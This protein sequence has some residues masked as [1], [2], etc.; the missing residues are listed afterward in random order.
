MKQILKKLFYY[1][2]V[3]YFFVI[4]L[5]FCLDFSIALFMRW[6][7]DMP[8][9]TST[10]IGF[11]AAL[12]LNYFL[13]ETWVYQNSRKSLSIKRFLL[14][15]LAALLTLLVRWVVLLTLA[16]LLSYGLLWDALMLLVAAFT[17]M[18]L[19]Y[20]IISRI[21]TS[22]PANDMSDGIQ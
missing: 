14:T 2:K 20:I 13:F 16:F 18:V 10:S 6:M 8:L 17:S 7:F 9:I 5:G 22:E 1:N 4:L 19:N 12:V 11:L 15:S 21:F 3:R